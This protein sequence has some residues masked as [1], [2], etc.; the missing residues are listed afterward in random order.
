MMIVL[1]WPVA[2]TKILLRL[3]AADESILARIEAFESQWT[4]AHA[5]EADPEYG[6][7]QDISSNDSNSTPED[8]NMHSDEIGGNDTGGVPD[9]LR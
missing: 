9:Y 2:R 8:F 6:S 1:Q 3:S 7:E 5:P 4:A